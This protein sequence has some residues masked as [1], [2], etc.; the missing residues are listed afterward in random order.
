MIQIED[1][2]KA[3]EDFRRLL[4]E[5]PEELAE[6]KLSADFWSLKEIVGHLVDS[7]SNNHQ[8]F[9]R[10]QEQTRPR[11]PAYEGE[12]WIAIQRYRDADWGMLVELWM[13]YNR[14]LLWVVGNVDPAALPNTWEVGGEEHTL[15]WLIQDYY[16]HLSWHHEQYGKRLEQL[17]QGRKSAGGNYLKQTAP[18]VVP[19]TDGKLIEEHFGRAST[20]QSGLSL[21][22]MVAPPNWSEPVQR[23]EFDEYTLVVRGR[24]QVEV[25]GEVVTLEAGQSILVPRNAAVRYSNPFPAEVEYVSVCLPAFAPE[26]AHRAGP[27]A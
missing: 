4:V 11:F 17:R 26:L 19:T 23:P 13:G 22:H 20:G 8:R 14:L 2:A 1:Y 12:T 15:E 6:V 5:T 25:D 10:L 16:R 18:Y 21:A 3:V 9:V 24:K 27:E 7:A